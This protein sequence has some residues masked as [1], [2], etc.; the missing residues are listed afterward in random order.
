MSEQGKDQ[1][2]LLCVDDE[3]YVLNS[4]TRT[5]R[6]YP[7][8]VLTALS[9]A[10]A[11]KI[12]ETEPVRVV[13]ADQRMPGMTG[14]DLL[15]IVKEKWPRVIRIILSG[16]AEVS[17]LILAINEGEIYRFI[18]KPWD[19]EALRRLVIRALEHNQVIEDMNALGNQLREFRPDSP[20]DFNVNYLQNAVRM[21]LSEA[22]HP[23]SVEQIVEFIKKVFEL[24][25]KDQELETIS[26]ALV[27]Q[28]GKLIFMT[29]VGESMQ[30]VLEF[31]IANSG[32]E[33]EG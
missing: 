6:N 11:L 8:R 25:N 30:L 5:F 28:K 31:P 15:S 9:G 2:V 19:N 18:K 22:K 17:D 14:T 27:R 16:Y 26:G 1:D 13:I 3:E 7:L 32:V 33:D 21:E 23:L 10:A 29:E 12:M 24:K 4:L 20:V